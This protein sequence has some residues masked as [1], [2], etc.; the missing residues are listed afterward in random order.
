MQKL[1]EGAARLSLFLPV[2]EV[3]L[4]G[5]WARG[6]YT[7]AS[8]VDLL[9]IYEGAKREDAFSLV[10]KTVNVPR[11]EPHVY[12][13]E[14]FDALGPGFKA[15]ARQ[16][17]LIYKKM[18]VP[19]LAEKPLN[20]FMDELASSAPA[21]GGGSVAALAGAM[22]A[23]LVSMVCNLTIGKKK[24]ADVEEEIKA[25][26]EQS[27]ALRREF[28]N[29]LE[30]DVAA[31]TRVSEAMK[32]PRETE[33]QKAIREEALDKALKEATEVP[34]RV[35]EACVRVIDLCRPVAE[36]GNVNAVS[37]AGVAVVM[38]EAGLRSAALNVLINLGWLK[39]EDFKKEAQTRLDKLLEGKSQLKEEIYEFVKSKL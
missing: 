36:K 30:A 28:L 20:Q 7:V 37:D 3:I 31:Y 1:R 22:G 14:E 29:L 39:D 18:E 8:D 27:E 13:E 6:T 38:A 19:M 35:A 34:L 26:L 10:K 16:G 5:S 12:T 15:A 4:F 17:L 21:P 23:A 9:V 24:Y 11:L 25:I 32:M 2:K 33:E